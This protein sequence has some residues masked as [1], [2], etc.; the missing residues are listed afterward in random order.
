MRAAGSLQLAPDKVA[1]FEQFI[2]RT[3]PGVERR[4]RCAG[5][6]GVDTESL[7]Q[8]AYV[9]ALKKWS[10][11]EPLSDIE[12]SAW[13]GVTAGRL[14]VDELRKPELARREW[15]EVTEGQLVRSGAIVDPDIRMD[16]RARLR[17]VCALIPL[18]SPREQDV[19]IMYS[20][21]GY[22]YDEVSQAL[23]VP[24]GA[25]NT[26]MSRARARLRTLESPTDELEDS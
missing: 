1:V 13:V 25:V 19:V 22:E 15:S 24:K 17:Q 14:L 11:V 16:A 21:L 7:L 26:A 20:L 18:L 6:A 2:R 5:A 12:Q 3:A 10:V 23:G 9:K 4:L 8:E